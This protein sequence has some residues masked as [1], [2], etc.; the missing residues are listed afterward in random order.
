MKYKNIYFSFLLLFTF[1]LVNCCTNSKKSK[2][3][4]SVH[5]GLLRHN[6][7][8]I[9]N[10]FIG[11]GGYLVIIQDRIVGID[12]ASSLSQPPFY[13]V[14]HNDGLSTFYQFGNRGQGPDDF[15]YPWIIQNIDKQTVGV[16]DSDLRTYFEFRIPNKNEL[17]KIDKRTTFDFRLF[18]I[19]KTAY[20]QYIALSRQEG[21]FVLADSAGKAINTFFEYPYKNEDERENVI[22]QHRAYAYQG[23]LATNPSKTKFAYA[24]SN[25]E[26]IH[27]YEIGNNIITPIAIIEKEYPLYQ[28]R[29]N[30]TQIGVAFEEENTEGYCDAYAT[31]Q[32]VYSLFGG[33]KS[34]ERDTYARILRVFDWSGNL[35]KEYELDLPSRNLCVTDDDSRLWTIS[36]N[37]D[38]S[39]VYFDLRN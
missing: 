1:F 15:L 21:M 3:D 28:N 8:D 6:T 25:G 10:D 19:I 33:H 35:V 17:L 7:I 11:L 29:S 14:I 18:R 31:E 32:F 20:N 30:Q 12:R 22:N 16:Y 4:S 13:C 27:F 36:L 37:P 5:M 9:G 26:I 24:C 38:I 39:L 23:H 2:S 34:G